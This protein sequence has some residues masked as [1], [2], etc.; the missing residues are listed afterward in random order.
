MNSPVRSGTGHPW[1]HPGSDPAVRYGSAL[2]RQLSVPSRPP[3]VVVTAPPHS[4]AGLGT[5]IGAASGP[6]R[7]PPGSLPQTT[8]ACA[9]ASPCVR[10]S[11]TRVTEIQPRR[12]LSLNRHGDQTAPLRP[13]A[14][15]VLDPRV[16]QQVRQREPG[17]RGP[18]AD[19]AIGNHVLI[20]TDPLALIEALEVLGIFERPI[21]PH[22]LRP[23]NVA[24]PG[25]VAAAL[26]SLLRVGRR[27]E[28]L[29]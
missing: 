29:S 16:A 28:Q 15:V 10:D 5:G 14:V 9:P 27:R 20:R 23:G 22:V 12:G 18:L 3:W 6:A 25:D 21:L 1:Y 17:E 7:T 11:N 8:R 13:G 24:G 4:A 19:P 26:G 2:S